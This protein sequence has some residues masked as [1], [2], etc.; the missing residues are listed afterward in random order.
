MGVEKTVPRKAI[1]KKTKKSIVFDER[2]RK[3]FLTGFKKRKDERRQ[4]WKEKVERD[5]KNEIK[6]IKEETRSKVNCKLLSLL[7]R[8]ESFVLFPD[9]EECG[10][11]E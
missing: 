3:E 9:G 1:N 7:K 10:E 5:L 6:K 2:K 8:L 4:K 11:Q